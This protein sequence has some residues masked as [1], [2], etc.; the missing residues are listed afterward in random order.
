MELLNERAGLRTNSG[1]TV[2]SSGSRDYEGD[3]A[4]VS[5]IEAPSLDEALAKVRA[6]PGLAYGWTFDVLYE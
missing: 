4:G 5:L 1:R 3:S 6:C 2:S